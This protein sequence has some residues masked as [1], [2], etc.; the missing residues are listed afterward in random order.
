LKKI[1]KNIR[2]YTECAATILGDRLSIEYLSRDPISLKGQGHEKEKKI[3]E[4]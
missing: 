4:K 3:R 2:A 1:H